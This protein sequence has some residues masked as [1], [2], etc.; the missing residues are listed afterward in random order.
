VAV[1]ALA[2]GT[3][4]GAG[5]LAGATAV[6]VGGAGVS[7][8]AGGASVLMDPADPQAAVT[9]DRSRTSTSAL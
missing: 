3:L 5:E 2:A 9:N 6:A 1:R 4:V 7:L 8:A